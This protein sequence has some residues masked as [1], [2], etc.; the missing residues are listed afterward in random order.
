[1]GDWGK[2]PWNNDEAADWFHK[3]WK[4]SDFS[5]L[6]DEIENFNE[7]EERYDSFRAASYVLQ[8]MGNPYIWPAKHRQILKDLLDKSISILE[9]MIN[10][11][12]DDWGFLDMWGNDPGVI[13]SVRKQIAEL[14]VRRSEIA[15]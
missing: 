7:T 1:M 13:E 2:E 9:K 11:P 12:N 10:P 8:T 6:I 4:N 15:V 14:R 5:V 3:F